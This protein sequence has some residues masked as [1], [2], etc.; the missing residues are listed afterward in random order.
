[1][2]ENK[3]IITE[4]LVGSDFLN[5]IRE[6]VEVRVARRKQYGDTFLEDDDIFLRI[7]IEN[8]VKRL[9]L[10]FENEQVSLDEDKRKTAIDSLIDNCNYSLFLLCKLFKK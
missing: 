3:L 10:Q 6:V 4:E 5:A 9:K 2:P 7:Q 1:M 8:K